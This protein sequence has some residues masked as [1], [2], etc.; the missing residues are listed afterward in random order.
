MSWR[1]I[2]FAPAPPGWRVIYAD[3]KY[4]ADQ[5]PIDPVAG[6]LTQEDGRAALSLPS[7][8]AAPLVNASPPLITPRSCSSVTE[9]PAAS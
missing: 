1:T 6:W 8:A 2:A 4:P 3:T 7:P 9:A 5:G